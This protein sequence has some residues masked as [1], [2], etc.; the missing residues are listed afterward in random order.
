MSMTLNRSP[1]RKLVSEIPT[2]NSH[3]DYK[4]FATLF[5]KENGR[6]MTRDLSQTIQSVHHRESVVV[7]EEVEIALRRR[8]LMQRDVDH[9]KFYMKENNKLISKP[10]LSKA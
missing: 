3:N 4:Y 10:P 8:E 1:I 7:P 2:N 6:S 5:S 9:G